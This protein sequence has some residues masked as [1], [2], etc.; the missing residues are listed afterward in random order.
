MI[1]PLLLS[2]YTIILAQ[3]LEYVLE[4]SVSIPIRAAMTIG[5]SEY[6]HSGKQ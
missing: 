2:F 1:I 4:K 5:K 6:Y 3:Q